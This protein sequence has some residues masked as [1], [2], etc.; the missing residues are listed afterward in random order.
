MKPL[1]V[2]IENDGSTRRLLDVLLTRFGYEVDV[3][4]T[5]SDG[6]LLLQSYDPDVV[7]MDLLIQG[8]SS[9]EVLRWMAEN[10]PAT[11]SRTLL[12]TAA[13]ER[14]V[15]RVGEQFP[16]LHVIRKPFELS[17]V[18]DAANAACGR[19]ERRQRT[20][21]EEF[22]RRS[23]LAGATAG[24]LMTNDG[25]DASLVCKFGYPPG[26]AE[27]YF[28]LSIAEAYPI[29]ASMR[30]GRAVWFASITTASAEYPLLVSIW[31]RNQSR[32]LAIVPLVRDERVIGAAGWSFRE[33]RSF[34]D[35]EKQ[36]FIAIGEAA[37][38]WLPDGD[39]AA[40]SAGRAHA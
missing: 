13:A 26:V 21:T 10:R 40:Q 27:A 17:D 7:L 22:C 2:V 29:C 19:I 33:P 9:I 1:A 24:L 37:A 23:I 31:E 39:G 28:P 12:V 18:V 32:A 3:V 11:V 16:G 38:A 30:L 15:R 35:A 6:L 5:G 8:V 20:F 36:R 14:D 34:N 25:R 4:A